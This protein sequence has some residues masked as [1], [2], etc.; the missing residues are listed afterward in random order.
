M[1]KHQC[2]LASTRWTLQ[3]F[4]PI[5]KKMESAGLITFQ[6][7]YLMWVCE[8]GADSEECRSQC[9]RQGAYCC[10]DPDDDIHEGYSGA[11]VLLVRLPPAADAVRQAYCTV[12][13]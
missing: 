4:K 2:E 3:D 10:P 7:H 11:D 13:Q 9:I 1:V 6:P 5:A 8:Y 12:L